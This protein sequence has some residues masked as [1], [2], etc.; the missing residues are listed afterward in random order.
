MSIPKKHHYVPQFYLKGFE[1]PAKGKVEKIIVYNKH[2]TT[3][4]SIVSTIKDAGCQRD[5]HT[6]DCEDKTDRASVEE[7]LSDVENFHSNLV[8]DVIKKQ[9]YSEQEKVE[10]AFFVNLM[11]SRVPSNKR[12][13]EEIH[14]G[15]VEN[16]TDILMN[17]GAFPEPPPEVKKI[18]EEGKR[19]FDVEISNWKLVQSMFDM[20]S[21]ERTVN[22]IANMN[23]S[24]IKSSEG[25]WFITSDTPVSIY[26]PTNSTI[27]DAGIGVNPDIELFL[28]LNRKYGLLCSWKD[29]A[30]YKEATLDEIY[31]YNRRTV[32]MADKYIYAS[33]DN[34]Q[35]K[36]MIKKY[37]S[38]KAGIQ[39]DKM[40]L[41]DKGYVI[42]STIPVTS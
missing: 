18:M 33:S 24:I 14:K 26:S 16:S 21:D 6:I 9:S 19:W 4:S 12:H 25:N 29:R 13:L 32:I 39:V 3:C 2:N 31:E 34:P 5:Y 11:R 15:A 8:K 7:M 27:Y 42:A 41:D 17:S 38:I 23:I 35:T 30:L 22:L 37:K 10:L 40:S 28:P 20:A 36:K 1:Y